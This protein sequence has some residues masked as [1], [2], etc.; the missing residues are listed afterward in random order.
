[1]LSPEADLGVYRSPMS[2]LLMRY[3]FDG[4]GRSTSQPE[5]A[6]GRAGG[7]CQ[8]GAYAQRRTRYGS[9]EVLEAA[10][11]DVTGARFN[12]GEQL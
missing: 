9:W 6:L 11:A 2:T 3:Q 7:D 4:T 10:S 12:R 5:T 1:M 8:L